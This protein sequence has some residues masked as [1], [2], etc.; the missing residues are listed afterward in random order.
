MEYLHLKN[1]FSNEF[2]E[3]YIKCVGTKLWKLD[4]EEFCAKSD[5][6]ILVNKALP[7]FFFKQ[8]VIELYIF[9]DLPHIFNIIANSMKK[10]EVLTIYGIFCGKTIFDSIV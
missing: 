7:L 1:S 4:I 10:L 9:Q 5:D 2:K 3:H 6:C 8:K